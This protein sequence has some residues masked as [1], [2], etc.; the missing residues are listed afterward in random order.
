MMNKVIESY[1]NLFLSILKVSF[2]ILFCILLSLAVV[3][4]LWL[5]ATK[6]P[7]IYTITVSS[8]AVII[9][10]FFLFRQIKKSSPKAVIFTL[11][12][13]FMII[14][15]IWFCIH[16]ILIGQRL[17]S[18]FVLVFMFFLTGILRFIFK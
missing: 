2:T 11:L 7:H 9:T 16:F 17:F 18:L 5:F 12:N 10:L 6:L 1:K 14:A 8:C 4:P 3:W 13:I 15:G